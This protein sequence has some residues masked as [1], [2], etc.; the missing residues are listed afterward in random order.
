MVQYQ[1]RYCQVAV[2]APQV[3]LVPEKFLQC[4]AGVDGGPEGHSPLRPALELQEEHVVGLRIGGAAPP[5][6]VGV[7]PPQFVV[8]EFRGQSLKRRVVDLFGPF[9]DLGPDEELDHPR[10]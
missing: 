8:D 6:L 10:V 2:A 9:R 4:E 3:L 7:A 1:A 5:D